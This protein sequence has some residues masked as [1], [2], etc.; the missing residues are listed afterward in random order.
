MNIGQ[1]YCYHSFISIYKQHIYSSLQV[2]LFKCDK[3]KAI[4]WD[5]CCKDGARRGHQKY[6]KPNNNGWIIIIVKDEHG[7]TDNALI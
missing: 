4:V 1:V 3:C 5:K 6:L 2:P 7:Q